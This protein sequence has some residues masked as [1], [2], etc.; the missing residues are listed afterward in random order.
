MLIRARIGPGITLL[1][2]NRSPNRAPFQNKPESALFL[3]S[4][5]L[6]RSRKRVL[7]ADLMPNGYLIDTGKRGR[8]TAAMARLWALYGAQIGLIFA[9]RAI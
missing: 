5:E 7:R 1:G 9:N 8:K 2:S 3:Q 6:K 4:D